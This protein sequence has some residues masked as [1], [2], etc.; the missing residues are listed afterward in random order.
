M[1][2]LSSL[3]LCG[4]ASCAFASPHAEFQDGNVVISGIS[5]PVKTVQSPIINQQEKDAPLLIPMSTI[6]HASS[7]QKDIAITSQDTTKVVVKKQPT[8]IVRQGERYI[9]ALQHWLTQA[10]LQRVA[11][12][13][14]PD[15]TAALNAPSKNGQVFKGSLREAVHQLSQTINKPLY[16]TQ[17]ANDLAAVHTFKGSVDIRWV[18]GATL[19]AAIQHLTADYHWHWSEKKSW[20]SPDDYPLLASYPIVVPKNDFAAALNIV[21]DGY[22]V[23]AQQLT[24]TKALFIVEK[25]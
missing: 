18:H 19:K 2:R 20:L 24:A 7:L 21:L 17:A 23:M 12:S 9:T 6:K 22:P 15:V 14:P 13:L 5:M 4:A 25:E 3:V 8:Y 10:K 1:K 16:F 11:Y